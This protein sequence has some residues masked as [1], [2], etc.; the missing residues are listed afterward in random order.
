MMASGVAT[1]AC[2]KWAGCFKPWIFWVNF[3]L[4]LQLPPLI[5]HQ[6]WTHRSFSQLPRMTT[7]A[8][9]STTK[10]TPIGATVNFC[11]NPSSVPVFLFCIQSTD[12]SDKSHVHLIR[13]NMTTVISETHGDP[14]SPHPSLISRSRTRT[15]SRPS[16]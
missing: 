11:V 2:E 16:A 9:K 1:N 7:S 15:R 12:A 8:F 10:Q 14:L 5:H 6:I 13:G 3:S 4:V